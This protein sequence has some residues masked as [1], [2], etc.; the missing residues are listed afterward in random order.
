MYSFEAIF[1]SV[2]IDFFTFLYILYSNSAGSSFYLTFTFTQKR[3]RRKK[4]NQHK[5]KSL[6]KE[7][8]VILHTKCIRKYNICTLSIFL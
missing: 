1:F 4:Q 2:N 5:K 3:R 7:K 8:K 6:K